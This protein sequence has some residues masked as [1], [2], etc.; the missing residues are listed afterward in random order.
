[1]VILLFAFFIELFNM[2]PWFLTIIK[3]REA[4]YL[5]YIIIVNGHI[6]ALRGISRGSRW[7]LFVILNILGS[8]NQ[9]WAQISRIA[10]F[11]H[12]MNIW[13]WI[14][15]FLLVFLL[16]ALKEQR[17]FFNIAAIESKYAI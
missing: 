16:E 15:L 17:I 7:S 1:M 12:I 8:L 14:T 5:V 11:V 3:I 10:V 13:I 9:I 4:R 6:F 2:I